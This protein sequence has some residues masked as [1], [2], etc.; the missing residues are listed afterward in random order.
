MTAQTRLASLSLLADDG[1]PAERWTLGEQPLSVG[2]GTR[3]DIRVDDAALS[4]RHFLILREGKDYLLEDLNSRNGTFVDGQPAKRT[5]LRHHDCIVAG[6]S[7]FV[8]SAPPI[9]APLPA[10]SAG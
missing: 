5:P 1:M 9:T 7:V 4:R 10:A 6:R 2:R 8:F 3:A